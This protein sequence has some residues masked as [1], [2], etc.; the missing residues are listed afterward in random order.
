MEIETLD[1][2]RQHGVEL[3][4]ELHNEITEHYKLHTNGNV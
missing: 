2:R 1:K 3:R 4:Q